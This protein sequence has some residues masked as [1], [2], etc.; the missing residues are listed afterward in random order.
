MTRSTHELPPE[1]PLPEP[2]KPE[3]EPKRRPTYELRGLAL[4]EASV[5]VADLRQRLRDFARR[6]AGASLHVAVVSADGERLPVTDVQAG[7]GAGYVTL[8]MARQDQQLIIRLDQILRL[9][10]AVA[11]E[12]AEDRFRG[13]GSDFGFVPR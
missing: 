6:N 13:P 9:E 1:V 10:L 2:Q 3:R 7:P 4:D 12:T 5:W 8:L 11:D